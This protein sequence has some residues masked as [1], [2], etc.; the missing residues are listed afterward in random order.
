MRERTRREDTEDGGNVY[1]ILYGFVSRR[2]G[3]AVEDELNGMWT[4][5]EKVRRCKSAAD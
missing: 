5:I 2:V 4:Q 1:E 3:Q